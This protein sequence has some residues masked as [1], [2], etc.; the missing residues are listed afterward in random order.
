MS[1]LIYGIGLL[2]FAPFGREWRLFTIKELKDK[3]SISKKAGM[4]TFPLETKELSDRHLEDTVERLVKEEIGAS[5]KE[6]S[7]IEIPKIT[8][9]PVPKREDIILS[10]AVGI[11]KGNPLQNFFPADDDIVFSGWKTLDELL[12]MPLIRHEVNPMITHFRQNF[13]QVLS[14]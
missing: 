6:I 10:Y 1:E 3:P 8:F 2:L 12:T 4:I 5:R 13:M 11:F 7:I 9:Q 14:T